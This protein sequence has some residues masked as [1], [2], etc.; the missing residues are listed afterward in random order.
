[1]DSFIH[2]YLDPGCFKK[3]E[4]GNDIVNLAQDTPLQDGLRCEL[5]DIQLRMFF[6]VSQ[7]DSFHS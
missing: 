1:M 7:S 2:H 6:S 3:D 5:L 4:F